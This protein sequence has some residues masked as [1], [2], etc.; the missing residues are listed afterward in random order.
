MRN[1]RGKPGP[2]ASCTRTTRSPSP[3]VKTHH[4]IRP[5]LRSATTVRWHERR[6][7]RALRGNGI[8]IA[9]DPDSCVRGVRLYEEAGV[10]EVILIMQRSS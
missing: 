6:V 1:G 10:D 8:I 2:A 3:E 7:E 9:G 4:E 5:A